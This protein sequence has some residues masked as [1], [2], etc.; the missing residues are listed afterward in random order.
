MV[1]AILVR[2]V[3]QPPFRWLTIFDLLQRD[4]APFEVITS[5]GY[6]LFRF[7]FVPEHV[8]DVIL[9]GLAYLLGI[10][11]RDNGESTWNPKS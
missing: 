5:L 1:L 9:I 10:S 2:D 4:S 3:V 11:R 7:I 6:P 8:L